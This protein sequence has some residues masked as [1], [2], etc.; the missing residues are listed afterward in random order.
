MEQLPLPFDRLPHDI[1]KLIGCYLDCTDRVSF[2][3]VLPS[4]EDKYTKTIESDKHHMNM[5]INIVRNKIHDITMSSGNPNKQGVLI[6]KL[7]NYI[8]KPINSCLF[9]NR[10]F[11]D[12]VYNKCN[13]LSDSNGSILFIRSKRIR[14]NVVKVLHQT[15]HKVI[16]FMI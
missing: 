11:V 9:E 1:N 3:R 5:N 12:A 7:M 14:K 15:K 10:K 8:S 13:E 6:I 2:F 16:E 4:N